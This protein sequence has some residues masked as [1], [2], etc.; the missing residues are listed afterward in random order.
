MR[1]LLLLL[2]VPL[3]G[4]GQ[5][6]PRIN[7][8]SLSLEIE[9]E[10][11]SS[12][13]YDEYGDDSIDAFGSIV[14]ES[15][16]NLVDV[17]YSGYTP[18]SGISF[19]TYPTGEI[20]YEGYYEEGKEMKSFSRCWNI[21]GTSTDC[22]FMRT[23]GINHYTRIPMSMIDFHPSENIAYGD[24]ILAHFEYNKFNGAAYE[25]YENSRDPN[26]L[27]IEYYYIEGKLIGWKEYYKNGNIKEDFWLR[28]CYNYDVNKLLTEIGKDKLIELIDD[29]S[30]DR[31]D[32]SGE[33][34][35]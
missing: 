30:V 4:L 5:D 15:Y 34:I 9:Y 2:F 11:K 23:I 27:K 6:F 21:N 13:I 25:N 17:L 28:Y 29:Y 18:F 1:K 12:P 35:R 16:V 33:R 22:F 32:E 7:Y 31:W 14:L 26:N 24:T 3:I 10:C 19:K 20:L 8:D